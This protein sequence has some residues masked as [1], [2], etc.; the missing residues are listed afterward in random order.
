MGLRFKAV[1]LVALATALLVA[2]S[3]GAT[4]VGIYRNDMATTARRAELV[5]LSGASCTRGGD[6]D[7]LRIAVGKRTP[8]CSYRTPVLGRDLEIA[9]TER[10]L[11]GTPTAVQQKAFLGLALR[12]GGGAKY[13]LLVFPLQSK[14]QLIKVVGGAT[15]Y[16]AIDRDEKA[17]M[18]INKANALRLKA[19]NVTSGPERGQSHLF[20]YIGGVLAVEATDAAAS[21]LS[22]RASGVTVGAASN[23]NGVIA[24]V[25]DIVIRVPGPF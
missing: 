21:D 6:V 24:S 1:F 7:T 13:Q 2:A 15:E 18:G 8:E 22:G 4:M 12:A 5:K 17:V 25:D 11:S 19:V 16:L 20:G 14:A 3:A 10:L 9:A 23:S